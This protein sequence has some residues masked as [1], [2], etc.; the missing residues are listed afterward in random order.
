MLRRL[1]VLQPV[2]AQVPHRDISGQL[3]CCQLPRRLG[4]HYLPAVCGRRDP[5]RPVHIHADVIVLLDGRLPRMQ[6]HPDPDRHPAGPVM[7]RQRPLR[8][9]AAP[10]GLAG[11][12]EDH[13][14]AVS[15]GPHFLA[16]AGGD[17]GAHQGSLGG[18]RLAIPLTQP[19][20]ESRRPLDVTEE[21]R[22]GPRRKLAHAS[23]I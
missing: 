6:A 2:P 1:D 23:I 4:Q 19:T 22:H 14:E 8:R 3:R 7:A 15:F 9:Q 18:Q 16:V 12:G 5:R 13:E 11:R 20:Q 10:Y 21:H 17:G